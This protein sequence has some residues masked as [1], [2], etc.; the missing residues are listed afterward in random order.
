M[1]GNIVHQQNLTRLSFGVV[2]V[3]AP[4]NRMED[5]LPVVPDLLQSHR[6]VSAR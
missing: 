1:D 5:L 4:S 3:D 2:V 6:Y